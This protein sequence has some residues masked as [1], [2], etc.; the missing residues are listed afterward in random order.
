V[1]PEQRLERGV[2]AAILASAHVGAHEQVALARRACERLGSLGA[3]RWRAAT[4]DLER[5]QSDLERS[6]PQVTADVSQAAADLGVDEDTLWT[7]GDAA[8]ELDYLH[9]RVHE[10]L[11]ASSAATRLLDTDLLFGATIVDD[12]DDNDRGT[13]LVFA[14]PTPLTPAIWPWEAIWIAGDSDRSDEDGD[15][16]DDTDD[17]E[18]EGEQELELFSTGEF[19][20][21]E[22][23]LL[24]IGERVGLDAERAGTA[25]RD[26]AIAFTRASLLMGMEDDEHE[27]ED[28]D[29]S[30]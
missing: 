11:T 17:S 19:V 27:D 7:A 26:I 21:N 18:A 25:L 2:R 6:M 14:W 29:R 28:I 24:A 1:A 20:A 16:R 22:T 23:L 9:D 30:P 10:Q 12:P 13:T 8:G 5:L 3:G 15:G 4:R